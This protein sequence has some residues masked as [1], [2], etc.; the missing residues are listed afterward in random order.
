MGYT[1]DS[2]LAAIKLGSQFK[3]A[4]KKKAHY[5]LIVG[6]EELQ[7][8]VAQLKDLEKQEQKEISLENL[9]EEL[10]SLFGEDEHEH[11]HHEE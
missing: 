3:K 5:A 6:E 9:E 4:A 8:G 11:H 2:P 7:R 10:D 1:C